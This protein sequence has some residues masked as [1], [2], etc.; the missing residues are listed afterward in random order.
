M[1]KSYYGAKKGFFAVVVALVAV[2]CVAVSVYAATKKVTAGA[3]VSWS[4]IVLIERKGGER[5]QV[6]RQEMVFVG[7][8]VVTSSSSKAK[9]LMKDDTILSLAENSTITMKGYAVE[10]AKKERVSVISMSRGTMRSI[11]SRFFGSKDS[12]FRIETATAVAGIKGTDF[13]VKDTGEET[14]ILGIEGKVAVKSSNPA[15]SGEVVIEPGYMTGVKA[16]AAPTRPIEIP[17]NYLNSTVNE[18]ELSVTA[19]VEGAEDGKVDAGKAEAVKGSTSGNPCLECHSKVLTQMSKY[20]VPHPKA[21]TSCAVCHIEPKGKPVKMNVETPAEEGM[22]VVELKKGV[23]YAIGFRVTD[24]MSKQAAVK[25]VNV[26]GGEQE[27]SLSD[28]NVMPVISNVRISEVSSGLFYSAVVE[29]DTDT[30]AGSKVDYGKT[31]KLGTLAVN[32]GEV[33]VYL[34]R[35]KVSLDR[36]SPGETYYMVVSSEDVFG[37]IA[38]SDIIKFKVDKPFSQKSNDTKAKA[39]PAVKGFEVVKAGSKVVVKWKVNKRAKATVE[40]SETQTSE[41]RSSDQPHYPGLKKLLDANMSA[42]EACHAGQIHKKTVHPIGV[43]RWGKT[44]QSKDLP[45]DAAG[46]IMCTTCHPAHGGNFSNMLRK[47]ETQ[48]CNSCHK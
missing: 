37:N 28:K 22:A 25:P 18:T 20:S 34:N 29:W 46:N 1:T 40:L 3:V 48:L 33:N 30:P 45:Y 38:A 12:N 4:G 32:A 5:V 23:S 8:T 42:C 31:K 6:K 9:L 17:A 39:Y 35:H 36:L 43:V 19:P 24:D 15:V 41:A 44:T 47:E 21:D 27:G 7:D 11:V 26:V 13:I 16:G 2:V 10:P 14:R